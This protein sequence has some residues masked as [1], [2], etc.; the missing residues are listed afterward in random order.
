MA[1]ANRKKISSYIC[2]LR[3]QNKVNEQ[4]YQQE[5]VR[6]NVIRT[7]LLAVAVKC[8]EVLPGE[9]ALSRTGD[10][11]KDRHGDLSARTRCWHS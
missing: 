2:P 3:L 1:A 7:F 5:K 11:T 8:W 6:L 4:N 9:N 10:L